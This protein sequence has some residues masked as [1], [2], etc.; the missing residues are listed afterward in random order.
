MKSYVPTFYD[1]F[2]VMEYFVSHLLLQQLCLLVCLV[3]NYINTYEYV[4]SIY[5]SGRCRGVSDLTDKH[6]MAITALCQGCGIGLLIHLSPVNHQHQIR[7]Q[8]ERESEI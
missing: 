5:F 4:S 3:V 2:V 7:D 6:Q 1:D 8:R